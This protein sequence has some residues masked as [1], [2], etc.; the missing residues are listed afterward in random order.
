MALEER[1]TEDLATNDSRKI[2][3]SELRAI[4]NERAAL[5]D[6]ENEL[7]SRADIIKRSRHNLL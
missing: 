5:R 2:Q 3:A 7:N 1:K 4:Y 6:R